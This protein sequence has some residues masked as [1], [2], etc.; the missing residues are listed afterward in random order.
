MVVLQTAGP[1]FIKLGQWASTRRDLFTEDFCRALSELH[2]H[3]RTHSWRETVEQLEASLGQ[4]WSSWLE[5]TDHTPIGSGSVAQVYK[6]VLHVKGGAAVDMDD[7]ARND[8]GGRAAFVGG[9]TSVEEGGGNS[10]KEISVA[11]KVLHPN[12]GERIKRDIFLMKYV[13]SWVQ[14]VYPD[15]HWVALTE[16]VDEFSSMME[17]QVNIYA[18]SYINYNKKNNE[19]S[20]SFSFSLSLS[21]NGPHR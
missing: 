6:G 5:I 11:V 9:V 15:V 17:K 1:A 10:T 20:L 3:C 13:A 7:G 21:L 12:V 18:M 19:T 4:N 8:E 14:A 2:V 16:C